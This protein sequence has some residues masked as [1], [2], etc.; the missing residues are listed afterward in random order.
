ML[1]SQIGQNEMDL[2]NKS[3]FLFIFHFSSEI[4]TK[5]N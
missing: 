1:V 2:A 5:T 4:Q 3:I